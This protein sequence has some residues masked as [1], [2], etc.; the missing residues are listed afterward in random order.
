MTKL[1]GVD[2][3]T[4]TRNDR[5]GLELTAASVAS[6]SL[7]ADRWIIKD[8]ASTDGTQ[9]W[10]DRCCPESATVLTSRDA[11]IYDAMNISAS[12]GNAPL[13]VFMNSGDTFATEHSLLEMVQLIALADRDFAYGASSIVDAG[14]EV[15]V[16]QFSPFSLRRLRLGIDSIPMQST[17]LTRSLFDRLGGFRGDAGLAADQEFFY[18]AARV[19]SP[20]VAD[21]VFSIR[22]AG[23]VSWQ[24][25]ARA[26]PQDMRTYRRRERDLICGNTLVDTA[27][28]GTVIARQF[29]ADK[30]SGHLRRGS[31][32][33]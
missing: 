25:P 9:D 15:A 2:V 5:A 3:I 20:V 26:F 16:H 21:A 10:L 33:A 28:T 19:R 13:I 8:G 29:V 11:G 14:S 1:P 30:I 31:R 23:G 12:A 24:R 18:R 27:I 17:I 6:Q 32:C 22:T 4:I 7:A